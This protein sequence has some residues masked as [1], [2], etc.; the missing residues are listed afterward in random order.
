MNPLTFSRSLFIRKI[1]QTEFDKYLIKNNN[2]N[3]FD[4]IKI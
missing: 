3:F 2:I 1:S 4:K